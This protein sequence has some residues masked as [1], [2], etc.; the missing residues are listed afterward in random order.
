M[1]T[2]AVTSPAPTLIER[3]PWISVLRLGLGALFVSVFYENLEKKLYGVSGYEGL[4]TDYRTRNNA[5][6]I[7]Q[8]FMKFISDNASFFAPVQA[9]FE[10]SL[11]VLLVLGIATGLVALVAAGH[12][13]AL[14]ISE[15]GIFWVWELL[16]LMIV[17]VVVG[18]AT[19]P[20]L[21]DRSRPLSERILGPPTF[22][23]LPI[24][25]RLA[26]AVVLGAALAGA[27]LAAKT[28]GQAHYED[29]AW[30]AGVTY[31]VLVAALGLL[32]RRRVP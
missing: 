29:V 17:A 21:L 18:M 15:L 26:F 22:G 14:W 30:E 9:V 28:G 12:L 27:I 6:G 1:A 5:P 11:G 23:A 25:A 20:R 8:D 19:L 24:P 7:W 16:T 32:D 10:I 2:P 4:I 31:G 13:T 3:L